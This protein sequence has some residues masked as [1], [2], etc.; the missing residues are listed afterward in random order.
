MGHR[1]G[2]ATSNIASLVYHNSFEL[3]ENP[4]S[5]EFGDKVGRK[6]HL[7]NKTATTRMSQGLH[8]VVEEQGEEE[9]KEMFEKLSRSDSMD[10]AKKLL[11]KW[12]DEKKKGSGVALEEEEDG[13]GRVEVEAKGQRRKG[14]RGGRGRKG[15][16]KDYDDEDPIA[17][18]E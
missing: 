16:R 4:L 10:S 3:G 7:A 5:P 14:R 6:R 2:L 9:V 18:D 12:L 17:E 13:E 11:R 15:R 1:D 8:R